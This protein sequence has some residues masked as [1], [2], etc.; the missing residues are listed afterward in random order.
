[1]IAKCDGGAF[2]TSGTAYLRNGSDGGSSI[3]N[4]SYSSGVTSKTL[5]YT[6]PSA[7][8]YTI[9]GTTTTSGGANYYTDPITVVVSAP[10]LATPTPTSGS[11]ISSDKFT[12]NWSSVSGASYYNVKVK[13]CADATYNNT[14]TYTSYSNS[15][16]FSNLSC[17][18]CYQYQVQAVGS[19]G[20]TSDYS[21]SGPTVQLTQCNVPSSSCH[22]AVLQLIHFELI[23]LRF[24]EH[25]DMR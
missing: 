8:T 11:N 3:L 22:S 15:Y 4:A 2:S 25:R 24:Q 21:S 10:Q 1:M 9:Y 23:G 19:S 18:G 16:T 17:G 12:A 7:G 6:F 20:N 5:T 13:N 14:A